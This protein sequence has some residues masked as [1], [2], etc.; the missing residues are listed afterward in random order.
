QDASVD[1]QEFTSL[2]REV[3]LDLMHQLHVDAEGAHHDIAITTRGAASEADA[4]EPSRPVARS[5]LFK[6]AIFGE[7]PNWRRVLAQVGTTSAS[8][9]PAAI[10]GTINGVQ[11][12]KASGPYEDPERVTF[13]RSVDVV[14]DLH[15]GTGA[16]TVWTS[17]LTHDYVEENSA[18][19][20]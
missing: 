12:G 18:Y 5:A 9:E 2:L 1:A 14:S 15:A 20:S 4:V 7:D 17:D 6:A 8:V 10:D 16:A 3:C 13:E 11:V 19:S